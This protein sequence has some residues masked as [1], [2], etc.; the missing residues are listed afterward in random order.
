MTGLSNIRIGQK[1]SLLLL[2]SVVMLAC[3]AGSAFWSVQSIHAAM[4][5]SE[6]ETRLTALAEAVSA[7]VGQIAQRVATMTLLRQASP[8][9][10]SQLL[11]KRAEYL[12]NFDKIRTLLVTEEDKRELAATE[13]AA[14]KW[15]EADNQLIALLKSGKAAEAAA[16]HRETVVPRFNEIGS[17]IAA[18]VKYREQNLAAINER[19][20][21]LVRRAKLALCVLATVAL[22]GGLVF[23]GLLT[24]NIASPLAEVVAHLDRIAGGDLSADAVPDLRKRADEIGI[25]ARAIQTMTVSLRDMIQE[26]SGGIGILS[27]SSD[28]MKTNSGLMT[29]G[30][31]RV[32]DTVQ[33]VSAAAEQMSANIVSVAAGV[34]QTTTNLAHVS[35]ATEQMTATIGEIAGN[36]EK[37]RRITD[38]ATRQVA[39]INERINR[40]GAAAREIGRVTE[41]ITE[42]SSQ[43]NL[44][45]LNATIEAARAGAAGKGFAVVATEIKALAQQTALAT[46]DIRGRIAGIQSATAGGIGEIEKIS[47]VILEVS[48]IVNSIAAAIEEQSVTTRDIARS[49]A[50]ASTGVHD[51]NSRV[52]ETSLASREIAREIV[53]VDR[54]VREMAGGSDEVRDSAGRLATLA[55]G[56]RETVCRF[57]TGE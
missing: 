48:G 44:L 31:R 36:S 32:A 43:T 29:S 46:E 5:D 34:E 35:S 56:L 27:S 13:E 51:A 12:A 45:A 38:Q 26:V 20:E 50:E 24:R 52:S 7:D 1:I 19:A 41:A 22:L 57:R 14:A 33:S 21:T 54:S 37:A 18:Y 53:S 15:R 30:S 16:L 23:G 3:L 49:I 42:I 55:E 17:A 8:D 6:R 11:E 39:D 40:L 4:R 9:I 25:L 47:N 2:A 28:E 10:M